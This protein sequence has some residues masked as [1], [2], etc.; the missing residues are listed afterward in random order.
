MAKGCWCGQ[1]SALGSLSRQVWRSPGER[2][3][4]LRLQTGAWGWGWEH[5]ISG[6]SNRWPVWVCPPCSQPQ[7]PAPGS[8]PR[9][10]PTDGGQFQTGGHHTSKRASFARGA[11]ASGNHSCLRLPAPGTSEHCPGI[12]G[13]REGRPVRAPAS[14]RGQASGCRSWRSGAVGMSFQE[15]DQEAGSLPFP[16]GKVDPF[17]DRNGLFLSLHIVPD[18]KNSHSELNTL[19]DGGG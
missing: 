18:P 1:G 15:A 9:T 12:L 10:E 6:Q 14:P 13:E 4:G 2:S 17:Q 3:P 11:E 7:G 5:R 16:R 19:C 8:R